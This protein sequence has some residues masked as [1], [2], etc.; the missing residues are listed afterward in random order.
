MTVNRESTRTMALGY[1]IYHVSKF[2]VKFPEENHVQFFCSLQTGKARVLK[3]TRPSSRE[4]KS[5]LG[6]N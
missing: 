5:G 2:K 4:I 1:S 6:T 3:E